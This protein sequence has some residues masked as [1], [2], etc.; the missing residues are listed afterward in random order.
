MEKAATSFGESRENRLAELIKAHIKETGGSIQ[1]VADDIGLSRPTVTL[2]LNGKYDSDPRNVEEKLADYLE[3]ETGMRIDA[4]VSRPQVRKPSGALTC[5]DAL[6]VLSLCDQC[7]QLRQLGVIVGRSG[8]GK[9]HSLRRYAAS[10]KRVAYVECSDAMGLRDLAEAIA[11]ALG[12]PLISGNIYGMVKAIRN[13][14]NTNKEWLLIID[15]ADKLASK[16]TFKKMEML[17]NIKDQADVGMVIAGEERLGDLL[18]QP[19]LER[20][21]NRVDCY[22]RLSG[23]SADEARKYILSYGAEADEEALNE[24]VSRATGS[25]FGCFRLLDRTMNAVLR[26]LNGQSETRITAEVIREASEMM[27]IR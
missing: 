2:Y 27:L 5:R 25:R 12:L 9:T 19:E 3:R 18:A 13:F 22:A 20:M 26:V 21:V 10:N 1:A 8:V 14:L 23:L 24:L 16:D 17:R 7:S 4:G 6:A 15:E 11:D